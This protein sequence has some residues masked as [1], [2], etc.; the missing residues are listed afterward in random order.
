MKLPTSKYSINDN[1]SVIDDFDWKEGEG[2]IEYQKAKSDLDE[3]MKD[4]DRKLNRVL[5]HQEYEYLKSYNMYVKTKE[6]ELKQLIMKLSEKAEHA[7]TKDEMLSQM[8]KTIEKLRE[9]QI[10][11]EK[12]K[13]DEKERG[14]KWRERAQELDSECSHL[15]KNIMQCKKKNQLLKIA[16]GK[17]QSEIDKLTLQLN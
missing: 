5:Q 13:N 12:E 11:S 3:T 1:V 15:Q 17:L 16:C 7:T 6:R 9:E 10:K 8:E 2:V 14:R 4:L